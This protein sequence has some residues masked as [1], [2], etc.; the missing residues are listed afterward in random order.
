MG[1][2]TVVSPEPKELITEIEAMR[3]SA[4][5]PPIVVGAKKILPEFA[6]TIEASSKLRPKLTITAPLPQNFQ[7]NV[8]ASW[9]Q[10]NG[11]GLN[12]GVDFLDNMRSS[13]RY[14]KNSR[15]LEGLTGAALAERKKAQA[16]EARMKSM[17]RTSRGFITDGLGIGNTTSKF[18]TGHSWIGSTPVNGQLVLEFI[19]IEDPELEV[20]SPIRE[21]YKLTA[22]TEVLGG[23]ILLPPGP[24][25][26][27]SLLGGDNVK[28]TIGNIL[29]FDNVF[30]SDVNA[31]IDT[32]LSKSKDTRRDK[33]I[34]HAKVD[35]TFTTFYSVTDKDIDKIFKF[36]HP[37]SV[38]PKT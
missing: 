20:I 1:D 38:V 36:Q 13:S 27:G 12:D 6:I 29:V 8:S 26:I 28:I 5:G 22:P 37:A 33:K 2:P 24:S 35:V 17:A 19:A 21:L 23:A 15:D 25:V 31:D 16:S 18:L 4:D 9:Q 3:K 7:M 30:I 14:K 32:R 11:K 34:L 10:K